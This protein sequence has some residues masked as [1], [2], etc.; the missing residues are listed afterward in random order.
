[1]AKAGFYSENTQIGIVQCHP[2]GKWSSLPTCY[3]AGDQRRVVCPLCG[4]FM[5]ESPEHSPK[6][7]Y[8]RD[9]NAVEAVEM[10]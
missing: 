7:A 5:H 4:Y 1:M 6:T 9:I 10:R 8:L 2:C 3:T